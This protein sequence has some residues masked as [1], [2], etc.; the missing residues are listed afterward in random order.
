M[1]SS[2]TRSSVSTA[3]VDHVA[4]QRAAQARP[5][6]ARPALARQAR[7]VRGRG[8]GPLE[9]GLD[10]G[11]EPT[12]CARRGRGR[13]GG[14]ARGGLD[15][16]ASAAG[17]RRVPARRPGG[18]NAT[19]DAR[20][21]AG[22]RPGKRRDASARG[23]RLRRRDRVV[24][25]LRRPDRAEGG[26]RVDGLGLPRAAEHVR[27]GSGAGASR[28]SRTAESRFPSWIPRATWC[29]C[30][31]Q[32]ARACRRRSSTVARREPRSRSREGASRSTSR[33]R[34][35][36]LSTSWLGGSEGSAVLKR[37]PAP[38]GAG[39]KKFAEP[40]SLSSASSNRPF[41]SG[42]LPLRPTARVRFRPTCAPC[43]AQEGTYANAVTGS[44]PPRNVFVAICERIIS[45]RRSTRCPR[46]PANGR[47]SNQP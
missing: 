9:A 22:R 7:A 8:R 12:D 19:H 41:A 28:S 4:R 6:A 45:G 34:V 18:R 15:A 23:G 42:L 30:S 20:A 11:L 5:Q 1:T 3:R 21:L 33:S 26:T 39:P 35:R 43:S 16:R 14:A 13:R 27:R 36:S 47:R 2:C 17:R 29:S 32:S 40:V 31:E 37:S 46:R 44:R 24:G 25:G 10:A 38:C